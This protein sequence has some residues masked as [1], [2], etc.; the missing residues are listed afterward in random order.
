MLPA[1]TEEWRWQAF[2]DKIDELYGRYQDWRSGDETVAVDLLAEYH[3]QLGGAFVPENTT[4]L[5]VETSAPLLL[6]VGIYDYYTGYSWENSVSYLSLPSYAPNIISAQAVP[7][8]PGQN[9]AELNRFLGFVP[10]PDS[11]H[12]LA[13]F[14]RQIDA[15]ITMFHPSP[16]RLFYSG[17]L[18]QVYSAAGIEPFVEENSELKTSSPLYHRYKYEFSSLMLDIPARYVTGYSLRP[19]QRQGEYEA[20]QA[21]AHAWAELFFDGAGWL[22]FDATGQSDYAERL[23]SLG[24]GWEDD[25]FEAARRKL[26]SIS[27]G[28]WGCICRRRQ[29]S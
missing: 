11:S 26:Y 6:K 25:R 2:S 15:S 20:T 1:D 9:E 16:T 17:R 29:S 19:T 14:V 3:V 23:L 24:E 21:T 27:R 8:M 22:T 13:G 4:V 18:T 5:L 12:P 7:F 10:A 28:A